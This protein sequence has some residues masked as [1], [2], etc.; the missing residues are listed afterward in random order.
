M[1]A[2][3]ID[4]LAV[5]YPTGTDAELR[6]FDDLSLS[7][8]KGELLS[9][10]GPSGCGKTTFL[11]VLAGLLEPTSGGFELSGRAAMVFQRPTLM[12]WRT[13]V[14]NAGFG[15]ECEGQAASVIVERASG[16]LAQ[17][18]LGEHLHDYP[19]QLSEGMKQRVNLARAL[20]VQPDVLLLD[21]PFSALDVTTRRALQDDL[22]A[23]WAEGDLTVI[24]V[25]HSLEE[26]AYV[27]DRICI[28]SHKPTRLVETLTVE[29]PRPR[30]RGTEGRLAMLGVVDQLEAALAPPTA[31]PP[32]TGSQSSSLSTA[33]TSAEKAD[34]A[35][36]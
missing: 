2:V 7:V 30:A 35:S 4:K 33:S 26:V 15:L 36:P 25:S 28:L 24:F 17:M 31:T 21:E 34:S 13:V 1:T 22:L 20:L 32:A 6:V 16:L 27:A 29:L 10:I 5:S 3:R 11:H 8:A 18:G 12:P 19:H 23:R 9:L 14:D